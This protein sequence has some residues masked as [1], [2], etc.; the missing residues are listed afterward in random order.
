[1]TSEQQNLTNCN[2]NF[3]KIAISGVLVGLKEI[4]Q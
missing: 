3:V 2:K 4:D 1:M